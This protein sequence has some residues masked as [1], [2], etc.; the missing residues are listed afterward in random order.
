MKLCIG[1]TVRPKYN[2]CQA[3]SEFDMSAGYDAVWRKGG[4][5]ASSNSALTER[6]KGVRAHI[7]RIRVR[8]P[9]LPLLR[10]SLP[11]ENFPP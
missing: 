11:I 7:V 1:K 8:L 10:T 6:V 3:A 9:Q 4:R 5:K 2:L